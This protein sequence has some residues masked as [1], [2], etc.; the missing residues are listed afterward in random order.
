MKDDRGS[1]M[2]LLRSD[3]P[4]FS[5]F[6]EVYFSSIRCQA[7]KAWRRNHSATANFAVPVGAVEFVAFD[8]RPTSPTFNSKLL[9]VSG[10]DDY[11]LITVPAG[12]WYGFLGL[13]PSESL[14]V[15]LLDK[16]YD[17]DASDRLEYP[18]SDVPHEWI[19]EA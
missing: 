16:P 1:V 7:I 6:G 5:G 19:L 3:S 4:Q 13:A 2:H 10:E 17:P 14:I 11:Q 8:S 15:N 9:I 18:S 12:V